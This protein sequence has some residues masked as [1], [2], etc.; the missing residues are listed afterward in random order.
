[1]DDSLEI[2]YCKGGIVM[3][4]KSNP[5]NAGGQG[6]SQRVQWPFKIGW[7]K[8]YWN[9]EGRK[10]SGGWNSLLMGTEYRGNKGDYCFSEI[11]IQAC[12][13]L[14][15]GSIDSSVELIILLLGTYMSAQINSIVSLILKIFNSNNLESQ[16]YLKMEDQSVWI[17]N[18]LINVSLVLIWLSVVQGFFH[19]GWKSPWF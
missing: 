7:I 15:K 9:L 18:S 17:L 10:E 2:R 5:G 13:Q 6:S 12:T 11:N 3:L 1:M 4:K 8:V 16:W 14:I 19:Q